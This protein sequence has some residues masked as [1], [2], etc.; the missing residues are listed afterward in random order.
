MSE[1]NQVVDTTPEET[2]APATE[3]TP[4]VVEPVAE[5]T[6][7]PVV[8]EAPVKV[9][10]KKEKVVAEEAP[11]DEAVAEEAVAEVQQ[12]APEVG[13]RHGRHRIYSEAPREAGVR[14]KLG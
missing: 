8:E 10:K 12:C 4:A 5:E 13:H 7:A 6:P 11:K 3:P 2:T 1:E 9:S 14:V